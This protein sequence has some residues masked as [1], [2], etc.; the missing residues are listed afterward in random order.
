[1]TMGVSPTTHNPQTFIKHLTNVRGWGRVYFSAHP[2]M[3]SLFW[4][5]PA[6]WVAI[7]L[8]WV[9][10][11][12]TSLSKEWNLLKERLR[13]FFQTKTSDID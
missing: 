3:N 13:A 8:L 5:L 2:K 7:A 10:V 1:M 12:V 11:I 6:L 9:I 4:T